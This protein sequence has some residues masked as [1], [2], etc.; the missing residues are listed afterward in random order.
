MK[1]LEPA[2]LGGTFLPEPPSGSADADDAAAKLFARMLVQEVRRSLPEG[3]LL[4]DG[5]FAMLES[6]RD[7]PHPQQISESGSHGRDRQQSSGTPA[8]SRAPAH[9]RALIA[10]GRLT[11]PFGMRQHPIHGDLRHHDGVDIAA[12]EGTPIRAAR[13]GRV[14]RAGFEEGY[15]NVV[16]LDHGGGLETR[17]AHCQRLG[18]RPGDRVDAGAPIA[19]VGSTGRSTGPHLHFEVRHQG[20]PVDPAHSGFSDLFP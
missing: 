6:L 20:I 16:V 15:G 13:A 10:G 3:G 1:A 12:P 9:A 7:D 4:G 5:P 14:V 2:L 11:S 8:P 17:Y 19:T 18:V